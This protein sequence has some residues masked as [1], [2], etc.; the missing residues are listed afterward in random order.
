VTHS[1]TAKVHVPVSTSKPSSCKSHTSKSSA[2]KTDASI[3]KVHMSVSNSNTSKPSSCKA[4]SSQPSPSKSKTNTSSSYKADTTKPSTSKTN[5]SIAK[6]H[7]PTSAN[8]THAWTCN[9]PT[10]ERSIEQCG[11]AQGEKLSITVS[12]W[13]PI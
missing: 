8:Q 4:N 6:V 1:S 7:M 5:A 10:L 13:S 12:F 9:N 3:P 2:S 11:S